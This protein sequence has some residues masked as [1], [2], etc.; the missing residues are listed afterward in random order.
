MAEDTDLVLLDTAS[1]RFLR[2]GG[3]A[4]MT[5]LDDRSYVRVRLARAFPVSDL[6]H[7]YA[8]LDGDG[9]DI[10]IIANPAELDKLMDRSAY[11]AFVKESH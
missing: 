5:L 3:I 7:Y 2:I 1:V 4:R 6:D 9:K 10:G 11:E 8:V